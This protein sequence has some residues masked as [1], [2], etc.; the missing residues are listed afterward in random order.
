M[1]YEGIVGDY[2]NIGSIDFGELEVLYAQRTL[3]ASTFVVIS[4]YEY[5]Q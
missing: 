2:R 3:R 1:D 5:H 4:E